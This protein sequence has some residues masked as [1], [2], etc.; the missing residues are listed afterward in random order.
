MGVWS[1]SAEQDLVDAVTDRLAQNERRAVPCWRDVLSQVPS[2]D[3]SPD[4]SRRLNRFF[5]IEIGIELEERIGV[6]ED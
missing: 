5:I 1:E 4:S 3:V 2:V 6:F